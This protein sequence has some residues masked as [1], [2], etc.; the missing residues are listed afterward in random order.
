MANKRPAKKDELKELENAFQNMTGRTSCSRKK[1][2]N[3]TSKLLIAMI[4]CGLVLCGMLAACALMNKGENETKIEGNVSAAGIDLSGMTQKEAAEALAQA[5]NWNTPIVIQAGEKSVTLAPEDLAIT[6]DAEAA[7]EAALTWSKESSGVFDLAPYLTMN[8]AAVEAAEDSLLAQFPA[9]ATEATWTLEGE[10]PALTPDALEQPCQA[11][12]V[13]LGTPGYRLATDDLYA[14]LLE[15]CCAGQYQVDIEC[16]VTEA[17]LPDLQAIYDEVYIA[18]ADAVMDIKTLKVTPESYG[19][20][21]DLEAAAQLLS[22]AAAGESITIPMERIAPEVTGES[23]TGSLYQDVL[24]SYSTPHTDDANRNTNLRLACKAINGYVIMP[25]EVFSYN[26]VLGK[27]TEEKGYKGAPAY[28]GGQ[29]VDSIGGGICQV[30]STLYYCTLVADLETVTRLPHSYVPS[31]MPAGTDATVSWGGPE[32]KFRNNTN[33]P[34]RIE[35]EV[36]GGK[37]HVK[38]LGTDEKDYVI[39]LQTKT[40]STEK[41]ETVYQEYAPDN[42]EG[43]RDGQVIVTPYSGAEV[44]TYKL[45]YSKAT[46]E[47]LETIT[48]GTSK[49]KTRDKVI[50]VIV[51]PEATQPSET[52]EPTEPTE[53]PTEETLPPL[54]DHF[55]DGSVGEDTG[56]AL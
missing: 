12:V 35:A 28:S 25:G 14:L 32:F 6:L 45:K 27:R 55:F 13:T 47:L 4:L 8:T 1:K 49:Y 15:S 54:P 40:I 39:E 30:S 43:Y 37:V 42:K 48:V 52:P 34:I 21:F 19:Y 16:T 33:Y 3:T 26:T 38:L 5:P 51:E 22:Q 18:P 2:K 46:G 7:A 36:S 24:A 56:G 29:T 9:E 50:C 11:L 31:Y 20:G 53:P 44:K 17:P 23:L 41:Y 10:A